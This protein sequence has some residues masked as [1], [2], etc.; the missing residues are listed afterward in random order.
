M[1]S[2]KTASLFVIA[3]SI[4]ILI[5]RIDARIKMIT[6]NRDSLKLP[7]RKTDKFLAET[8][9]LRRHLALIEQHIIFVSKLH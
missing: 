1:H 9:R 5:T 4:P 8:R 6:E 7:K 2:N 3:D